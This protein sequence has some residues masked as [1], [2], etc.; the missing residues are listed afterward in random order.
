MTTRRKQRLVPLFASHAS[1]K[2]V[3]SISFRVL[4]SD[5]LETAKNTSY[6][7]LLCDVEDPPLYPK[8]RFRQHLVDE[9][10]FVS[11]NVIHG[12][13]EGTN[14]RILFPKSAH[15]PVC[16]L[17][18]NEFTD[19]SFGAHIRR[20]HPNRT[21]FEK[22]LADGAYFWWT[23][24]EAGHLPISTAFKPVNPLLLKQFTTVDVREAVL[25]PEEE[26]VALG[27]DETEG[28]A[29]LEETN[30]MQGK[31]TGLAIQSTYLC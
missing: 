30:H 18:I 11:D 15:C 17:R 3:I 24:S 27:I 28:D 21:E 19:H 10:Q 23:E 1:Q 31:H 6:P 2:Y 25:E 12:V 8:N 13:L 9:H 14:K 5:A 26:H 4:L 29:L 7:C 20:P 22:L 16:S